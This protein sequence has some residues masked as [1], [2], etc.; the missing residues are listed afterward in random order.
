MISQKTSIK[1]TPYEYM[2]ENIRK[3][4][5]EQESIYKMKY[6]E[7]SEKKNKTTSCTL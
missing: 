6:V 4:K 7:T 3:Y 5:T 2:E 1:S